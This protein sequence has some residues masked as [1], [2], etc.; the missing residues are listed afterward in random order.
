MFKISMTHWPF[1]LTLDIY[2]TVLAG[3]NAVICTIV[4][5]IYTFIMVT[6]EEITTIPSTV[7]KCV[8]TRKQLLHFNNELE[9]EKFISA[10]TKTDLI[11]LQIVTLK[12]MAKQT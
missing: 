1:S 4:R 5:C 9:L 2:E 12:V 7:V 11:M 10:N 3:V 6:S 8:E